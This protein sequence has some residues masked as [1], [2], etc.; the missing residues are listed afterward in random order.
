MDAEC[1][2]SLEEMKAKAVKVTAMN[3]FINDWT[4]SMMTTILQCTATEILALFFFFF[5]GGGGELPVG[6]IEIC[7]V[8]LQLMC[9]NTITRLHSI[10]SVHEMTMLTNMLSIQATW[11]SNFRCF[12]IEKSAVTD[13]IMLQSIQN[14][15]D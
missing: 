6:K 11:A 12:F 4:A 1:Y 14:L 10:V 7:S 2:P 13:I 8:P 3:V 15:Y 9:Q 5:F